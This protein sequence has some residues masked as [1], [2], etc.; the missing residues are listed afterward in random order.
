MFGFQLFVCFCLLFLMHFG[1]FEAISILFSLPF[2]IDLCAI[3]GNRISSDSIFRVS[4]ISFVLSSIFV[5]GIYFQNKKAYARFGKKLP[6][7]ATHVLQMTLPANQDL[8]SVCEEAL[9]SLP[10]GLDVLKKDERAGSI[11]CITQKK[12]VFAKNDTISCTLKQ[13]DVSHIELLIES[14][15]NQLLDLIDS[16][17]NLENLSQIEAYINKKIY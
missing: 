11:Y 10:Q 1:V 7:N 5:W 17:R 4:Q 2:G 15:S 14:R 6:V 3:L 8:F 13:K 9:N 12:S 16:G